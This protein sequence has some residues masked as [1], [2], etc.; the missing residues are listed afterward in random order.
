M[1]VPAGKP[2]SWTAIYDH[3]ADLPSARAHSRGGVLLRRPTL[4]DV[5]GVFAVHHDPRVYLHDPDEV[6]ADVAHTARFLAPTI[7]H[8][9][10]HGFGHWTV[11]VPHRVWPKGKPGPQATD[12]GRV[13]AGMG[14]IQHRIVDG[15][16]VLNV[17]YRFAPAT[18]GRGLARV[19][20]R[21]SLAISGSRSTRRR[22][23]S[24]DQTS[25]H[26]RSSRRRPRWIRRRR[27]G[28]R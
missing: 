7:H 22:R 24:A 27:H 19:V 25:E 9:A 17:Y 1:Q 18:Q 20:L 2:P 6:H 21:Q 10:T 5:T 3:D 4:A 11:L 8:W 14:G 13:I 15:T 12:T 23:G 26:D 28:T 16:P